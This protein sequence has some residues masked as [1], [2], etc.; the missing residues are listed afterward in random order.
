MR[1]ILTGLIASL[2]LLPVNAQVR[3]VARSLEISTVDYLQQATNTTVNAVGESAATVGRIWLPAQAAGSKVCSTAGPCKIGLP[4]ASVTWAN[5]ATNVR[6]GFQDVDLTTGLEDGTYDVRADLVPGTETVSANTISFFS[7]ETGSKTVSHG[8]V[9]AI[10]VEMTARGGTDSI[11]AERALRSVADYGFPYGTEDTGSGVGK[12]Q[13]PMAFIIQ[14]DDGTWGWFE[15]VYPIRN[16]ATGRSTLTV[17]TGTNPDEVAAI[18]K[19]PV[20]FSTDG[21]AKF[22]NAVAT[23]DEFEYIIYENPLTATPDIIWGP[24]TV[25]PDQL[26]SDGVVRRAEDT[27]ILEADTYYAFSFRPTTA[28][29][30]TYEYFALPTSGVAPGMKQAQFWTETILAGRINQTG[31]FTEISTTSLPMLVVNV[32]SIIASP[33][34]NNFPALLLAP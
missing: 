12:A 20:S 4:A 7:M 9:V 11:S 16:T 34:G 30:I 24:V 31:A 23:T 15:S 17:N 21:F 13:D 10:V 18:V 19:S 33:Y 3:P 6:L 8:D 29:S 28:N 32:V 26:V 25:D 27:L 2:L 14:F 22:L 1:L 5:A